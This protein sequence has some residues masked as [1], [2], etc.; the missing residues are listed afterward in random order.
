LIKKAANTDELFDQA[1]SEGM[2]TLRQD[3]IEKV[4]LGHTDISE[5]RRVCI[6]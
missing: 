1:M 6:S 5:V 3:G 4:L 2:T